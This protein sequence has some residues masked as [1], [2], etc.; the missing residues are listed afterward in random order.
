MCCVYEYVLHLVSAYSTDEVYVLG[1]LAQ[2]R[3]ASYA[4]DSIEDRRPRS[5]R[6]MLYDPATK[7]PSEIRAHTP[8]ARYNM[9]MAN[10]LDQNMSIVVLK[11]A[12][13]M[14]AEG[15]VPDITT[16][17][18]IIQAC[19]Q[20]SFYYEAR[21]VIEDMVAMGIHP[22]RQSFHYLIRVSASPCTGGMCTVVF[23]EDIYFALRVHTQCARE[24]TL[25][26]SLAFAALVI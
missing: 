5:D 7:T 21:S 26:F 19:S 8:L 10:L 22:D 23:V 15:I 12:K 20:Q 18:C 9:R 17:N 25:S 1:V 3:H 4:Q 11:L 16:Y 14:K 24:D 2:R 13:S 6:M